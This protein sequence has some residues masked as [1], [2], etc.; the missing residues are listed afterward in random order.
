MA[1]FDAILHKN[2]VHDICKVIQQTND[3][4][5]LGIGEMTPL[6]LA[7]ET[8]YYELVSILLKNGADVNRQEYFGRNCLHLAVEN[9][10]PPGIIALLLDKKPRMDTV[11]IND[12]MHPLALATRPNDLVTADLLL[13][14]GAE[15]DFEPAPHVGPALRVGNG[16]FRLLWL[17][18]IHGAD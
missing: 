4:N 7:I 6:M 15:V 14:A 17:I 2:S 18:W 8:N 13:A 10:A 12:D 1:L 9:L 11:C 5:A 3:I 16:R